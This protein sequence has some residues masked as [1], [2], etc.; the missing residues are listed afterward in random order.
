MYRV[1]CG[2]TT[3]NGQNFVM[4]ALHEA[5][6]PDWSAGGAWSQVLQLLLYLR[7]LSG[8][9]RGRCADD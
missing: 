1:L 4:S 8:R 5:W 9:Y 2:R 6:S 7:C 3:I